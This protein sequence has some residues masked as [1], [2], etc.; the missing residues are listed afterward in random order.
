MKIATIVFAG[1]H[2]IWFFPVIVLVAA[3]AIYYV[4]WHHK[5]IQTL[6][7][8]TW[9]STLIKH[10]S[11]SRSI[12]KVALLI[13]GLVF[14]FIALLR[15]Q[16][17]EKEQ[18]IVQHGRDLMIAL[19]ISRSML[20]CDATPNRLTVAKQK[21]NTLLRYLQSERVGLI[22]FS[23][24]A[25]VQC[26]LTSD[27]NAFHLFLDHVDVETI[28][29]GTTALEAAIKQALDV[30]SRVAQRKHKLLVIF[31]DGE[32]F[33]SNLSSIKQ[34][35]LQEGMMIFTIGLGTPEGAPIPL[36]DEQGRSIGHQKD[37]RGSVVISRL[38]EEMLQ[39][40]SRESGGMYLR[41]TPDD[42]DLVQLNTYVQKIEKEK[43]EEKSVAIMEDEYMWFALISFIL[44][45]LEWLL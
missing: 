9:M 3:L 32:D 44:F 35:A 4:Y 30:F 42:A 7:A 6:V 43:I 41:A 1:W 22:L 5:V 27:Y 20:A 38:N 14:L 36:C 25:F 34:Q 17:N 29:S 12:I 21:I 10:Y 37:S 15:P 11:L 26:P 8:H 23:G 31:T 28:S 18:M 33:S 13:A 45:A 2:Y 16:W 39:A 24:S 40:L 19:D